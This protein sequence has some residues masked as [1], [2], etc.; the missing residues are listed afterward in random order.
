MDDVTRYCLWGFGF[1]LFFLL[2]LGWLFRSVSPLRPPSWREVMRDYR[3]A[4]TSGERQV[5]V[6]LVLAWA[7]RRGYAGGLATIACGGFACLG[8]MCGFF[9]LPAL[10]RSL[11]VVASWFSG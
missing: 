7:F 4:R 3:R 8:A 5:V 2:L 6:L 9:D 10:L 11:E 1:F